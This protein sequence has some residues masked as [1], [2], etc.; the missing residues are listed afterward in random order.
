[1]HN[2]VKK[3]GGKRK[4]KDGET[5]FNYELEEEITNA[6]LVDELLSYDIVLA[7]YPVLSSELHYA[8]KPPERCMRYEKKYERRLCPL[9][10]ISWWR[11]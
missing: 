1:M 2:I 6:Q 8:I 3:N 10:E 5:E 7:T 9:V 4:P 11:V